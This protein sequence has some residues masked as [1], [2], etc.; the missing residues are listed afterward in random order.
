MV[1]DEEMKLFHCS[2][3]KS[4]VIHTRLHA[5]I[6]YFDGLHLGHQ[7]LIEAA[8]QQAKKQGG[9]AALI[10][11]EPDPWTTIQDLKDV[12]HLTSMSQRMRIAK[13][14]GV[15]NWIILD[16]TKEMSHLN[17]QEFHEKVLFP[18]PLDTLVCGY[19][20]HYAHLGKGDAK[21]LAAQNH[22]QVIEIAQVQCENEKI[23]STRIEQLVK[24]GNMEMCAKL[25]TRPYQIEGTIVH[26]LKNGRKMGFPTANLSPC[27]SYVLPKEGVYAGMVEVDGTLYPAMINVG[28][29][30]TIGKHTQ[31]HMEA[32][33]FDFHKTLYGKQV[34]FQ[35]LSYLREEQTFSDLDA[36]RS[37][38]NND[39][40]ALVAY[41]KQRK[42]G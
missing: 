20:F 41:F 6:G 5:C 31:N 27:I 23:S 25:L 14:Y 37:Q 21:T 38:L 4:P 12:P 24:D 39:Q 32:H 26:G 36:L 30:P 34:T 2:T 7:R 18:L 28:K 17:V 1:G 10:T 35:F 9:Q 15:E 42:D 11:F 29:N 19:D 3:T 13:K 16:F 33:L 8:V 22:F 40:L